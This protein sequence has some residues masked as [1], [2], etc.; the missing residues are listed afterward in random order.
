M[1]VKGLK[2]VFVTALDDVSATDDEGVGTIRFEGMNVY[3][4][5]KYDDG[6]ANLDLIPGD[7]V[8]YVSYPNGVVTGDQ[9][10]AVDI[11][12]AGVSMG[13]VTVDAS[14]FWIQIK[15][16]ADLSQDVTAGALGNAL[17]LVGAADKELDVSAVVTDAVVA[18]LVDATASAQQ[19]ACDFP[20]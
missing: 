5:V 4:Y 16:L 6:A 1:G 8:G 13:T 3:K 7:V 15:G 2:R 18:Y 20:F 11:I 12:G 10:S 14:Y 17:T 9:S 19:I